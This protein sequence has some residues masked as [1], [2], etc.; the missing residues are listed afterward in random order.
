GISASLR[1]RWRGTSASAI[2]AAARSA[3]LAAA[4]SARK[5]PERAGL[6]LASNSRRLS[7]RHV[8]APMLWEKLMHSLAVLTGQ[9]R[10]SAT[11]THHFAEHRTDQHQAKEDAANHQVEPD[12]RD[13]AHHRQNQRN[14]WHHGITG[15]TEAALKIRLAATQ[16]EQAQHAHNVH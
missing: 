3:S 16:F 7:K 6:A 13:Q 5:A 12:H 9:S 14:G 8:I 15:G 10:D 4:I 2:C 1:N 11:A